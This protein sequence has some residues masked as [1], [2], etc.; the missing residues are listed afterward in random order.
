VPVKGFSLVWQRS[1][2]AATGTATAT[3]PAT[4]ILLATPD[5][6]HQVDTSRR[7]YLQATIFGVTTFPLAAANAVMRS[8]SEGAKVFKAGEAMGIEGAKTRFVQARKDLQYLLDNYDEIQKGGGD[9]IRR[10]LGTVGVTSAMYGISKVMKELQEEANDIVE[11]TENMNEFD[12]YLRAADTACYSANFVE[13]SAA[14]T[15]PEKFF[16]DARTETGLMRGAM[17]RM[18]SEI[19]L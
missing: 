12:A 2:Q 10:Y 9:N 16:E 19:G 13:F 11:Y 15:K 5:S 14:K 1:V 7:Q 17:D 8:D 3:A 4:G 6:I 18:A